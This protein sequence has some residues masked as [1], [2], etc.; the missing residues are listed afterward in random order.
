MNPVPV[1]EP[2]VSMKLN[3]VPVD[4]PLTIRI[5]V[6]IKSNAVGVSVTQPG[7]RQTS[8]TFARQLREA[9]VTPTDDSTTTGGILKGVADVTEIG[10]ACEKF[11]ETQLSCSAVAE[12]FSLHAKQLFCVPRRDQ[13][14]PEH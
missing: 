7:G 10:G 6:V 13:E 8:A 4:E 5:S 1:L 14:F 11:R 12:T 3:S 2:L 9:T